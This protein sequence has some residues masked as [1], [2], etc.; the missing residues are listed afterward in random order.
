MG[1]I[2]VVGEPEEA[3][4][5][6][7]LCFLSLSYLLPQNKFGG[8]SLLCPTKQVQ[9]L[10]PTVRLKGGAISVLLVRKQPSRCQK[11]QQQ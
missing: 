2:V 6:G 5:G 3:E 10:H 4:G 8:H 1:F 9:R 11:R 7:G